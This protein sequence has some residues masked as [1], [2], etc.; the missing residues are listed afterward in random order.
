[1]KGSPHMLP[2]YILDMRYNAKWVG[3][4]LHIWQ[5]P[6]QAIIAAYLWEY[7]EELIQRSGLPEADGIV[8]CIKQATLYARYI[9]TEALPPLLTPP[10]EDLGALLLA[11]A[12]YFQTLKTLQEKSNGRPC[13][14]K[15]RTAIESIA[16]VL[17]NIFKL[18]GIWMLKREIEDL[19]E[20]LCR[21]RKYKM[22]KRE[23]ISIFQRDVSLIEAARHLLTNSY[24]KATQC[25]IFIDPV[26][27]NVAG[28]KRRQQSQSIISPQ[29]PLNGFDLITF[30]VI[31]PTVQD[32]YTAFGVFS[33]L[34]HIP[35]RVIDQ[36][37]NP[38]PNGSSSIFFKLL[39]KLPE[40]LPHAPG[41][42]DN[43]T[44]LCQLQIGTRLMNAIT[45]YGCLHPSCYCLYLKSS[46]QKE[47]A[48]P[49]VSELW[50]SEAGKVFRSIREN[51]ANSHMLSDREYP[52]IVYDKDHKPIR[53]PK[54]VT[55]LDFSYSVDPN[56]EV[57]SAAPF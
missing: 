4:Q 44:Y 51:L 12:S 26:Q 11:V 40:K 10:Y 37:T 45:W 50:H 56:I 46:Q 30:N 57:Y 48:A 31:V 47:S 24:E 34:G 18:L 13:D 9:E 1:M 42:R 21:P 41:H 2:S 8:N 16:L 52:L 20:Q 29:I 32:C 17:R 49:S 33:Q 43:Q 39:L 38:K 22:Q 14:V 27:C 35:E 5:A 53:L 28:L 15:K 54:G 6:W 19:S 55:A 36:L 25:P 3:N 23:L 7:D